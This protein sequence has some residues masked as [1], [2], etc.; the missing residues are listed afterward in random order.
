[1][2]EQL[3]EYRLLIERPGLHEPWPFYVTEHKMLAETRLKA[4][5]RLYV[6]SEP[7]TLITMQRRPVTPWEPVE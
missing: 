1:M 2:I 3:H 4:E 5:R 6:T 7:S